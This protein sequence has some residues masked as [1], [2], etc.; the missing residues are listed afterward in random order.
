MN[1]S[2]INDNRMA[3]KITKI[4]AIYDIIAAIGLTIPPFYLYLRN[5]L[6]TLEK[7]VDTPGAQ[8]PVI[9]YDVFFANIGGLALVAWA[10][11]RLVSFDRTHL[12]IDGVLKLLIVLVQVWA[13]LSGATSILLALGIVLAIIGILDIWAFT[14]CADENRMHR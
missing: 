11:A 3:R 9:P 8:G 12:L 2:N 7:A 10:I 5:I 4:S 6:F 13:V 1:K 14:R